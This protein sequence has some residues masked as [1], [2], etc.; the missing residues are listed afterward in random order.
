[1][2]GVTAFRTDL[3]HHLGSKAHPSGSGGSPKLFNRVKRLL[4]NR[5]IAGSRRLS[6][7]KNKK[8]LLDSPMTEASL[9]GVRTFVRRNGREQRHTTVD[10]TSANSAYDLI[11]SYH[12][13]KKHER[14]DSKVLSAKSLD[15]GALTVEVS[16]MIDGP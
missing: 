13:Y 2:G 4:G 1:M 10:D 9:R 15:S 7:V 5:A 12:Q 11:E 14:V 16:P 8:R 6:P 3:T